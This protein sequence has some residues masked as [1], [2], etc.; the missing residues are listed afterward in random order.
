M[1]TLLFE[2]G[3]EELPAGA[4]REAEAQ[5]PVL[6]SAS[7]GWRRTRLR[8]AAAARA[9]PRRHP[10]ADPDEWIKGPPESLA[11]KAA[12]GFA[13]RHGVRP[14]DLVVRDGF[15]GLERPGQPLR[16]VL[17]ERMDAI[18]RGLCFGK[19][20]RWDDCGIRFPRPVRWRLAKLDR[21]TVLGRTSFG[22]RFT[23]GEVEIEDAQRYGDRL[24]EAGVEPDAAERAD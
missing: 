21:E 23:Q 2:I 18:V 19:T 10:G 12:A 13:K 1:P 6:A 9:D 22:H 20:M 7:S 17:P 24:R 16:D 14:E 4:C 11:D 5:L 8:R 15:L 3:C